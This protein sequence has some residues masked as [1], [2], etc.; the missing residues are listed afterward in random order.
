M[1][2]RP[3]MTTAAALNVRAMQALR[4]GR[5]EDA[6]AAYR[7]SLAIEPKAADGWYN[8]GYALRCTRRFGDAAEAYAT[9]LQHGIARPEEV[10]LNR[11]MIL[12]EFLDRPDEAEAELRTAIAVAPQFTAALLNLGNLLEDRGDAAAAQATYRQVLAREPYNGRALARDAAIDVFEGRADAIPARLRAALKAPNLAPGA[13][14]EIGFALG[15][16]LDAIGSYREAFATF[17]EA[18]RAAAA[19]VHPSLRYDRARHE[20]FVD[21]L[22]SLPP[23]PQSRGSR[24]AAPAPTGPSLTAPSQVEPSPPEA[25]APLFICGMFRSGSTLVEQILSRHSRVTPG[26]ELEIIPAMAAGMDAYPEVLA[27]LHP[28]SMRHLAARYL[29]ETRALYPDAAVLTDKRPD[30]FLHIGL[31][32]RLFPNARIIH[33]TRAPL[34]T[35][36]SVYF[37][38][39]ADGVTYGHQLGDIAHWFGQYE[40]LMAHWRTLYPD[41]IHDVAYDD[42]VHAPAPT[43]A[44]LLDFCG[45]SWEDAVLTPSEARNTV[46]TASVWQVRQPLHQRSSGRWRNYAPELRASRAALGPLAAALDD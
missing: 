24:E 38:H 41:D 5:F 14:A 45:L 31:I 3:I 10:R 12:S 43:I 19:D 9:A 25:D 32:K 2:R 29:A 42:V 34:D 35:I 21:R 17:A 7:E 28:D 6:I 22:I 11:A 39:F 13:R 44:S 8:L 33:T 40:R 23:S 27:S 26:G 30:N 1:P 36:L 18:N 20:Q 37:L 15:T 46:R 4:A 16:A